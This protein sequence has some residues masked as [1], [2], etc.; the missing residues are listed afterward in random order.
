MF[1]GRINIA[2]RHVALAV[3][4]P[5]CV[6]WGPPNRRETSTR[7]LS[8]PPPPPPTQASTHSKSKLVRETCVRARQR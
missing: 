8:T 7:P 3:K 1:P 4:R 2:T 5:G 6:G